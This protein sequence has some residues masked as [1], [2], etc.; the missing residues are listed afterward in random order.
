MGHQSE[1]QNGP[2]KSI[3]K[4]KHRMHFSLTSIHAVCRF[5]L[6]REDTADLTAGGDDDA[7]QR[8]EARPSEYL[9]G[10][11]VQIDTQITPLHTDSSTFTVAQEHFSGH[12]FGP[13]TKCLTELRSI[14]LTA[15]LQI[16]TEN[17]AVGTYSIA[18]EA[19]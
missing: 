10:E 5:I 13:V 12:F 19:R 7:I 11:R 2:Q 4:V 9:S 3:H 6:H 18:F 17:A 16:V 15:H 1:P 14:D 8:Q